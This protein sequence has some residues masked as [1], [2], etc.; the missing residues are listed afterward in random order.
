MVRAHYYSYY[1]NAYS[2]RSL[3]VQLDDRALTILLPRIYIIGLYEF[4]SDWLLTSI[5][6][7]GA[8]VAGVAMVLLLATA[9][10]YVRRRHYEFFYIAHVFLVILII[11]AGSCS[12]YHTMTI[13]TRS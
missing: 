3:S 13:L 9:N 10:G 4:G 12:V 7:Y 6:T 2:V 8:D 5:G 1:G 11:V